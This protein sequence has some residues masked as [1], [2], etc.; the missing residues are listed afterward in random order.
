MEADNSSTLGWENPVYI[1]ITRP[2]LRFGMESLLWSINTLAVVL[3]FVGG[4]VSFANHDS[5][6]ARGLPFVLA[7]AFGYGGTRFFRMQAE[8][9]PQW[10]EVYWSSQNEPP[11]RDAAPLADDVESKPLPVLPKQPKWTK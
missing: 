11:M 3:F 9:D 5:W 7:L 2:H 6:L 1:S 10:W 8:H 4:I